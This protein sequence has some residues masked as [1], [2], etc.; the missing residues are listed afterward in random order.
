MLLCW[1]TL[2]LLKLLLPG[3]CMCCHE[4]WLRC[5]CGPLPCHSP[6]LL[7]HPGC[8]SQTKHLL[9]TNKQAA[10]TASGCFNC[11]AQQLHGFESFHLC[12]EPGSSLVPWPVASHHYLQRWLLSQPQKHFPP[13]GQQRA[14]HWA[15]NHDAKHGRK[16][17][18]ATIPQFCSLPVACATLPCSGHLV[19]LWKTFV[20]LVWAAPWKRERGMTLF[21]TVGGS[22]GWPSRQS[23]LSS[24]R[25]RGSAEV[26]VWTPCASMGASQGQLLQRRF[27]GLPLQRLGFKS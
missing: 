9:K 10:A 23:V 25:A 18:V 12:S 20:L 3:L 13:L 11:M 21:A 17:D 8:Y 16:G 27:L 24:P 1:H 19:V 4:K 26:A 7:F 6:D 14:T 22:W 15:P 2:H 5:H